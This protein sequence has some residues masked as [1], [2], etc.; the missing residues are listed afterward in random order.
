MI[1]GLIDRFARKPP[2]PVEDSVVSEELRRSVD[3]DLSGFDWALYLDRYPDLRAAGLS[4][5]DD[6]RSHW[7]SHGRSEGRW[8]SPLQ[9]PPRETLVCPSV[10]SIYLR[11][12]GDLV[13]WDDAGNDTVLQRADGDHHYGYDVWLGEPYERVRRSLWAGQMP[14]SETCQNCL[15][16]VNRGV[17]SSEAVDR[18]RI[19]VL[20]IEPSYKCSLDCPGCVP[21]S[22]RRAAPPGNLDTSLLRR[23]LVD[24]AEADVDIDA[25]DFQGHGEPLM[26]PELWQL[27]R[28]VKD[29]HPNTF[30]SVTTNC[31]G[32]LKEQ[33][34]PKF[35]DEIVCAI[36]G[37]CES[38]YARY[39]VGGSFALAIRFMRDFA[40]AARDGDHSTRVVWKYVL[41]EHNSSRAELCRAHETA[42]AAGVEEFRVVL[43]R[44]GA[45]ATDIQSEND[46]PQPPS[47]LKQTFERHAPDLG[48]LESRL[49][50][51]FAALAATKLETAG[52]LA[53]SVARGLH[54]FY[55]EPAGLNPESR[56][57][58]DRLLDLTSGLDDQTSATVRDLVDHLQPSDTHRSCKK[59]QRTRQP[60]EHQVATTVDLIRRCRRDLAYAPVVTGL[61]PMYQNDGQLYPQFATAAE[62][63]RI[64]DTSGRTY[65]DWM[66]GYGAAILGYRCRE[67]EEAAQTQFACG[68]LLPFGHP[69]EIEVAGILKR[70]IP[71]AE[72]VGFGKNGSDVVTAAIRIARL[73]TR[74]DI[75]LFHGYHGF[76]DWY[77]AS[78]ASIGGIPA[79]LGPL[80]HEFAW[81]DLDALETL[82][83]RHRGEVAAIVMEPAKQHLP[84]EGYL[85]GIQDLAHQH[86]VILV[87]DEIVTGF[88]VAP[89]GMQEFSGVTPD[90]ACFSKA[91]ANGWSIS[92]LVGCADLM[93]RWP[94]IGVDMTWRAETPSLAAARCV[95][96]ILERDHVATRL[97]E[98]GSKLRTAFDQRARE[99]EISA[100]L[101]GHP[102]RMNIS[103]EDH[104]ELRGQRLLEWFID[105]CLR[106]GLVTNGTLLPN[107]AHDAHAIE[108]TVDV[109]DRALSELARAIAA[110]AMVGLGTPRGPRVH[111]CLDAIEQTEDGLVVGGWMLSEDGFPLTVKINPR[112]GSVAT[113]ESELRP[114]VARA[115]SNITGA[116][117]SGWSATLA[118]AD[119]EGPER[120]WDFVIRGYRGDRPVLTTHV[121]HSMN[122][123]QPYLPLLLADGE[124]L[125][126][127]PEA[128]VS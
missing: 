64:T 82:L 44:N 119:G 24:L 3:I 123:R 19:R 55:R 20:Q 2:L 110:G 103:I 52:H 41:F 89:G 28:I 46:L 34:A 104:G 114:D 1:R 126:T 45:I 14:F 47:G 81:G 43:T 116:Q 17:H 115:H 49:C 120:E 60:D 71:C 84:K 73:V 83:L 7:I 6:A 33:S 29:L 92:A 12:S 74:R 99:L 109:F 31:Q 57:V 9:R 8:S 36:D 105:G 86:G 121:I 30:V 62:G 5:E 26:N 97:A 111:G 85:E 10:D 124:L 51:G 88:R 93:D 75:V 23:I 117:S 107:T 96:S 127:S 118:R 18:R 66:S 77:A 122:T 108:E 112:N 125:E 90:L 21:L 15:V 79:S 16:L 94:Q 56:L 68:P 35:V 39:R 101:T 102:S 53:L 42:I 27:T 78:D 128:E 67:V 98:T 106:R 22:V 48:D 87:W 63:C 72:K 70:Q 80:I 13:C 32:V 25:V 61:R 40:E 38:S 11:A 50:D 113:V 59:P 69:L 37:A 58:F 100:R 4:S 54:R 76:H 65:I 95:L 91:M